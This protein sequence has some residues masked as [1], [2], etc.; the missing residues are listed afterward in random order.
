MHEMEAVRLLLALV[1]LLGT[2]SEGFLHRGSYLPFY[3]DIFGIYCRNR[4]NAPIF[5]HEQI[6]KEAIRRVMRDY[7]MVNIDNIWKV[8]VTDIAIYNCMEI[9]NIFFLNLEYRKID[10]YYINSK[11]NVTQNFHII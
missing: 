9:I 6:T 3:G 7:Y 10:I 4:T 1:S 11:D 8:P 5:H 2:G